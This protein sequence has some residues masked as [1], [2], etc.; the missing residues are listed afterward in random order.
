MA[1]KKYIRDLNS[2]IRF[3]PRKR[4]KTPP[5]KNS[6][7]GGRGLAELGDTEPFENAEYMYIW[8][9]GG[10]VNA[11]YQYDGDGNAPTQFATGANGGG[12]GINGADVYD[13]SFTAGDIYKNGALFF[14]RV[15]SHSEVT[16]NS[17]RVVCGDASN[18]IELYNYDGTFDRSFT[19]AAGFLDSGTFLT[20][21]DAAVSFRDIKDTG[22]QF[23]P[24]RVSV[25]DYT[26]ARLGE[27]LYVGI[28]DFVDIGACSKYAFLF[29]GDDVGNNQLK[30]KI[31]NNLG[32][33]IGTGILDYMATLMALGGGT[34][35]SNLSAVG[36]TKNRI[37]LFGNSTTQT[38]NVLIYE[39]TLTI[40]GSGVAT[41]ATVGSLLHTVPVTFQAA[42]NSG[43]FQQTAMDSALFA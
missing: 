34:S 13:G 35:T 33:D 11:I 32:A 21:N 9:F 8:H 16:C 3:N 43:N 36:M 24:S 42:N 17:T 2:L 20:A 10:G 4:L 40:D 25:C 29:I 1:D 6:I 38:P 27:Y 22:A 14:D 12:L 30:L 37:Y 31:F 26:G 5:L 41:A 23:P 28:S 7:L 19:I 18:V 39:L 15:G